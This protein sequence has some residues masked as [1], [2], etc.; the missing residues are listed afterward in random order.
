MPYFFS[1]LLS[2]VSISTL[3]I[4][5]NKNIKINL[6]FSFLISSCL[7]ALFIYIGY[8]ILPIFYLKYLIYIYLIFLLFAALQIFKKYEVTKKNFNLI[9]EFLIITFLVSLFSWNRY[10]LDQDE[11]DY[12]GIVLKYF[13]FFQNN[14]FDNSYILNLIS[15]NSSFFYHEPFLPIFHFL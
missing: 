14:N 7:C 10:Y 1:I 11:L 8:I 4:F 9:I 15:K 12:W 6:I 5:I 3:A 2:I 13:H